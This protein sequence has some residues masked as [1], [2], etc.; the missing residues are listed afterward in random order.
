MTVY[1]DHQVGTKES[2]SFDWNDGG[3]LGSDAL[4][5]STWSVTP[6]QGIELTGQNRTGNITSLF[7]KI[8]AAGTYRL[9]NSVTTTDGAE[10]FDVIVLSA[11]DAALVMGYLTVED[12]QARLFREFRE[13]VELTPGDLVAAAQELD[14]YGPWIG[15]RK[16]YEQEFCFPR[17]INLDKTQNTSGSIPERILNA[18][19]LLAQHVTEDTGPAVT[20][21]STLDRSVTYDSPKLSQSLSRVQALVRPY[22][23]MIGQRGGS[24]SV[25]TEYGDGFA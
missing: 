17:T 5:G 20:S 14:S 22:Q 4:N 6:S 12:A 8:T 21:V 10:Y 15:A 25:Y 13:E 23:R 3:W 18:V 1:A 7:V 24:E 19:V 16:D 2:Y 9:K 11:S